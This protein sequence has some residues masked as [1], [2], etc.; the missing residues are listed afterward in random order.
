M[1]PMLV[2]VGTLA[3]GVA[4]AHWLESLLLTGSVATGVLDWQFTGVNHLDPGPPSSVPD[5]HCRDN[6]EGPPPYF[7]M[8]DKDVGYTT[9]AIMADPH[10]IKV[11]LENVYPSYFN[12]ISVYMKNTGTVPLIIEKAL[13]DGAVVMN[14]NTK[15]RLD[16]NGDGENDLEIW[17]RANIFGVQLEPG[18]DGPETS[19]WVH[20]LQGAPRGANLDFTIELL[21]VQ[22]NFT[23]HP[24][25]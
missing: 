25:L 20:V 12:S 21:A 11:T 9:A 2:V 22:Y 23:E 24:S 18:E 10:V 14:F 5:Y 8:G 13:I 7:W 3:T 19:F 15:V 16:L 17:W 1:L 4:F 6:F